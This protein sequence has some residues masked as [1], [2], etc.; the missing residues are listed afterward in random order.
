MVL[1]LH[2][3]AKGERVSVL[4]LWMFWCSSL[5]PPGLSVLNIHSSCNF[6]SRSSIVVNLAAMVPNKLPLAVQTLCGR[7]VERAET[8]TKQK[9]R[10]IEIEH[11]PA[12]PAINASEWWK[13]FRASCT[14][15][16]M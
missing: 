2:T 10:D 13:M 8:L 5:P 14:I 9:F 6:V 1:T 12:Q 16:E 7:A 4:L 11:T 3:K 15:L